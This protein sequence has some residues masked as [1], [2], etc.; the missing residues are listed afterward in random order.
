MIL[1]A[2]FF[3]SLSSL[4]YEV[5]LTR[6]FSIAQ[7]NHLSFM[8]ISI[9]LFGFGAGGSFLRLLEIEKAG[10]QSY[11]KSDSVVKVVLL[12][13]GITVWS[14]F[15]LINYLPLDY[16]LL[17]VDKKQIIYLF[18]TFLILT[19]PFFFT[20][21]ITALAYSFAGQRTG[22]LYFL[23]MSG[24]ALGALSAIFLLPLL[25]TGGAILFSGIIPL[26]LLFL[27]G[28]R[29]LLF[30]AAALIMACSFFFIYLYHGGALKE[31]RPSVYKQ[32]SQLLR[33]PE[34]E[35]IWSS[36]SAEGR[37][38]LVESPYLRYAPGL[39][40]K[41]SGEIPGHRAII[42][43]GDEMLILSDPDQEELMSFA[44]STHSYAGYALLGETEKVLIIQRGG[45]L[46]LP[47]ALA[48]GAEEITLLTELSGIADL[49]KEHYVEEQLNIQPGNPRSFL[50]A[51][52][53]NYDLIQVENWGSSVPGTASLSEEYL[54]T[55]EA[56]EEYLL[57]LTGRGLLI[58]SRKLLLPPS[59]SLRLFS[60]AFE[61]LRGL[62][63]RNPQAHLLVIRNWDS[64]SLLVSLSPLEREVIDELKDFC[65]TLNFDLVYYPG[66]GASE[67][68]IYNRFEQAF[69]FSRLERLASALETSTEEKFFDNYLLD[70]S[71]SRDN[72]PFHN[73]FSRWLRIDELYQSTGSRFYS[74][75]LSGEVV[76]LMVLFIALTVGAV[77]LLLPLIRRRICGSGL[78]PSMTIYF[79]CSGAGFI[80]IELA[81]IYRY[82]LLLGNAVLSFTLVLA[83]ML[84]F[85]GLAGLFI[86][87]LDRATLQRL[88]SLLIFFLLLTL[89]FSEYI[90]HLCLGFSLPARIAVGVI[91][92]FPVSF[93]M[94][95]PFPGAMSFL[96]KKPE[97]K[98]YAWAANGVASVIA[99][100]L[101]VLVAITLG[102]AQVIITGISAYLVIWLVL[103]R[104]PRSDPAG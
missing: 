70:V 24:S 104:L 73:R 3:L 90:V 100:V 97:A 98:V 45:G 54:F 34:T 47:A 61:A 40:L 77:L 19:L 14:S 10:R 79:L 1:A 84:S 7:W 101:A 39:S 9:V 52:H 18:L 41:Y 82:T 92:I 4:M 5:L 62:K 30:T 26:V 64:Y 37:I 15:L 43:D 86:K 46:A 35:V 72:R 22:R 65:S 71:P 75:F 50:A 33:L 95:F 93:L 25:E 69:H 78:G 53:D 2:V 8:V 94:G 58:V 16:F 60:T 13:F 88:L 80:L 44:R 20:G 102:I 57:H 38:D 31:V 81:F 91:L 17:P 27:P 87:R 11:L 89:L 6:F 12:L 51:N 85:S 29:R 21:V 99:A 76:I 96:L 48:G 103:L 68:N 36:D 67:A 59:D 83:C 28:R 32:L 55:V 42:R 74:L 63:I 49:L 66:I 23:A 56:F